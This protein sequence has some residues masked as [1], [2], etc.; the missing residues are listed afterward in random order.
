M[1]FTGKSVQEA[2]NTGLEVLGI[3]EADAEI[4]VVK[5]AVKGL[6]GKVKEN[7]VVNVS[8]K[9]KEKLKIEKEEKPL[10]TP[11]E[12][13][14]KKAKKESEINS[15]EIIEFTK[16]IL[17]LLDIPAETEFTFDEENNP[18]INLVGDNSSKLIG[19]RG[20]V[21][22]AIQTLVGAKANIG[23][24]EYKKVVVDCENYRER[25]KDTL[26]AL[27]KKLEA[28]AT[29]IRR[30]VILEP[31]NAFERR[32]IHTALANSETVTTRSD[33]KDPNR[34][35]VIVPNDLDKDSKPYN[36]G[37]KNDDRKGNHN[38]HNRQDN[39]NKSHVN[40]F[41]EKKKSSSFSFGTFLGNFKDEQ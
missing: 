7:A 23:N 1:E 11:K 24:E 19:Y 13:K 41:G 25:R 26:V 35:V 3:T 32:I 39:R 34:Y 2:I 8:E 30:E 20:E 37:R 40:N 16:K 22:D 29:E 17:E 9:K 18:V 33:G 21:L 4:T 6:F 5:E 15:E 14:E 38:G 28:K 10:K 31:M 36:A 12:K 27:A